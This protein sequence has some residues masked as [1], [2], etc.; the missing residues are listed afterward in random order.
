M[1]LVELLLI[2]LL[3]LEATY[4]LGNFRLSPDGEIPHDG[5]SEAASREGDG[6]V[7]GRETWGRP[8]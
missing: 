1:W 8:G 2:F 4:G 5:G 6:R 7:R 3:M